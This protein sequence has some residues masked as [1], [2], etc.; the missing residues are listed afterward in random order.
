MAVTYPVGY[1][2]QEAT[3]DQMKAMYAGPM[4]P[5][6]ARRLFA[7][8]EN[9]GGVVG[10]GSAVRG[11]S[12]ISAASAAG[13]SF[14]QMQRFHDGFVGVTAVDLV[15]RRAGTL[16]HSSGAVPWSD[17]P[18]QGSDYAKCWGLHANVPGESWHLQPIEIDGWYTWANSGRPRPV[19]GYEIPGDV[20][21]PPTPTPEPIIVWKPHEGKFGLWPINANKPYLSTK[22]FMEQ[23]QTVADNRWRWTGDGVLY[24][25]SVIAFKAGGDI[26]ID[27]YFGPQTE[28]RVKDVQAYLGKGIKVDGLVGNDTWKIIDALSGY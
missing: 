8:L 13:R 23:R 14:H 9:K 4:D 15:V 16:G 17:V 7:W 24:L 28:K 3:L 25:Q 22:K 5:E 1:G 26:T 2:K 12:N 19:P 20:L 21:P 11:D 10:I 27:G 6:Y 18:V